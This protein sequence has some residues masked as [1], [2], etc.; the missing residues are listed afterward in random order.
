MSSGRTIVQT[1][2]GG[3]RVLRCPY[4]W[5]GYVI[6]DEADL[7]ELVAAKAERHLRDHAEYKAAEDTA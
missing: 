7:K 6:P 1:L 3:R 4:C 2:D 5:L